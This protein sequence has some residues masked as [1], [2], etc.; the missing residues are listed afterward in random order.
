MK[1]ETPKTQVHPFVDVFESEGE[2]LLVADLP[3]VAKTDL[4][5]KVEAGELRLRAQTDDL[6]YR[7]TFKLGDEVDREAIDAKLELGQLEI[8][9]PKLAAK[10]TRKI[11][12]K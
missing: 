7:R 6:D 2:F 10:R 5:L 12:V 8:R 4:E 9:M 3:G 1:T 11:E